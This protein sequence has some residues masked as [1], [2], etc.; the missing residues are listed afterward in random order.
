MYSKNKVQHII[1]ADL[2]LK[3]HHKT[4]ISVIVTTLTSE[5]QGLYTPNT[6][7]HLFLPYSHIPNPHPTANYIHTHFG[8]TPPPDMALPKITVVSLIFTVQKQ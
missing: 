3:V 5:T 2:F 6:K 1:L 4:K 8:T 7:A